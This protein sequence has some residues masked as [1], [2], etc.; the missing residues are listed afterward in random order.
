MKVLDR[1][2]TVRQLALVAVVALT[3]GIGGSAVAASVTKEAAPA[4]RDDLGSAG[5]LSYKSESETQPTNT[6]QLVE[7]KCPNSK[8][9]TGGGVYSTGTLN[10]QGINSSFPIDDGDSGGA[11]D[12]GWAG[13]VDNFGGETE[14]ITAFAICK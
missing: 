13:W 8:S 5:G 11:P 12:D 14:T 3:V 4:P 6:Q 10:E 2:V 7:A 1:T 9:A